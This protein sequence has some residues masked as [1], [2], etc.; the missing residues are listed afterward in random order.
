MMTGQERRAF[1]C[2]YA[3]A[4]AVMARDHHEEAYAEFLLE[5]AGLTLADL[6]DA[7]VDPYDLAPLRPILKDLARRV[8]EGPKNTQ[9]T[10][11]AKPTAKPG[12]SK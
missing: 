12:G 8:G 11:T 7:R 2:G 10:K 1:V 3:A 9:K 4:T 5:G 6:K